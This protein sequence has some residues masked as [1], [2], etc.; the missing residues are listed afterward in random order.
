[1]ATLV[2]SAAGTAAGTA[3]GT[4]AIMGISGAVLGQAAGAIAGRIEA[5][6]S[7]TTS[8][9]LSSAASTTALA[10]ESAEQPDVFDALSLA[11][12]A[13]WRLCRST[14]KRASSTQHRASCVQRR[15]N[16]RLS[17][18]LRR[19]SLRTINSSPVS[20]ERMSA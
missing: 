6:V 7:A 10:A 19:H 12:A 2:L 11:L 9:M 3:M 14:M 15:F 8:A 17:E 13:S 5:A 18:P 4:G 1:M 20:P 16:L